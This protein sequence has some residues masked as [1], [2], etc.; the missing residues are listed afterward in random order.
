MT[1][2]LSVFVI[3]WQVNSGLHKKK[4]I[5]R[6]ST[7]HAEKQHKNNVNHWHI[8]SNHQSKLQRFGFEPVHSGSSHMR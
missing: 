8:G 3:P 2:D 5:H 1:N 7:Q 4:K 6:F